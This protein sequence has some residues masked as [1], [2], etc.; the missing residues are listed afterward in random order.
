VFDVNANALPSAQVSFSTTA[1]TL[2]ATVANTDSSGNAVTILRTTV[3]ATITATVGAQGGSTT[4]PSTGTGTTPTTPTPTGTSTAQ[5]GIDIA[6][7]PTLVITPPT[8]PPSAGLPATVTFVVTAA[9][10]NGS[11]V[12][13][14]T[15]NWGDGIIEDKGV[16]T[17]TSPQSDI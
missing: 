12:R 11:A 4:T 1:G 13:D 7:A 6:S 15:I 14:L 2:T 8:S 9:T 16:V 10:A 5:I 17:G 3:K